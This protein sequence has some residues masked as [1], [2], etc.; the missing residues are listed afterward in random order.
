MIQ[1]GKR[2]II[3]AVSTLVLFGAVIAG[4]AIASAED[5]DP[6]HAPDWKAG[7]SF[8]YDVT[9]DIESVTDGSVA[10]EFGIP[11][12]SNLSFGPFPV[13]KEILST[14]Y[15]DADG[16][17]TY[18]SAATFPFS[19]IQSGLPLFDAF[20]G[21]QA[22][23]TAERQNDLAPVPLVPD[24]SCLS[25]SCAGGGLKFLAGNDMSYLNFPLSP[26]KRWEQT[27]DLPMSFALEELQ[28]IDRMHV[29]GEVSGMRTVDLGEF[30]KTEAV[31]VDFS[32]TPVGLQEFVSNYAQALEDAGLTLERFNFQLGMHEIVYYS[33]DLQAIVSQEYIVYTF[34]DI[35]A[36]GEVYG[37]EI[38]EDIY[39]EVTARVKLTL[40]GA[41]TDVAGPERSPLEILEIVGDPS[42]I[43][44]ARGQG[45]GATP[46]SISL[47]SSHDRVNA[48]ESPMVSFLLGVHGVDELPEGTTTSF[49]VTRAGETY[50][51][52]KAGPGGDGF[53]MNIDEPGIY[54]VVAKVAGPDGGVKIAKARV[55]ADYAEEIK[56]QCG[57]N[58]LG[59][60]CMPESFP[61]HEGIDSLTVGIHVSS[62]SPLLLRE[63]L[64]VEHHDGSVDD[65]DNTQSVTYAADK[66][67]GDFGAWSVAYENEGGYMAQVTYFIESTYK[68]G[69][70]TKVEVEPAPV[71]G[72][73]S[74]GVKAS[75][76]PDLMV[77][78]LG[79]VDGV[80]KGL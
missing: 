59:T 21:Q 2:A 11:G 15:D 40:T 55:V 66:I 73:R 7:Y 25:D 12:Q 70:M 57:L 9:A 26:D 35:A 74:T 4:V 18:V 49:E 31:R 29:V 10:D 54:D 30:G 42:L 28:G 48:A 62:G 5:F 72:P 56:A 53:V 60:S 46:Y 22:Y 43:A 1:L 23:V 67:D 17:P 3:T 64:L 69:N 36:H 61:V 6:V 8:S 68:A 79:D 38:D 76:A 19:N 41:N 33:D 27:I 77:K 71:G 32:Y 78:L 51:G 65:W 45:V 58:L 75:G 63:Y 50:K 14:Q 34:V 44:D 80:L 37:Q 39:A 52:A 47:T 13:K 20:A 16:Y 24:T